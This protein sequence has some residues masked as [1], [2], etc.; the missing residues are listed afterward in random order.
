MYR[1]SKILAVQNWQ[2]DTLY[3]KCK[4]DSSTTACGRCKKIGVS[5]HADIL[6]TDHF[7]G[8]SIVWAKV[9]ESDENHDLLLVVYPGSLV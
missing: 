2:M 3:A 9:F 5:I 8:K 4:A 1:V 6:P 7:E